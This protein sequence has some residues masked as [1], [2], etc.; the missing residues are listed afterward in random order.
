VKCF[1]SGADAI[2]TCKSCGRGLSLEYAA[3]FP[4]GLACKNRCEKDVE[5]LIALIERNIRLSAT[6]T[7]LVKGSGGATAV[8]GF[9]FLFMGV[10]FLYFGI[11]ETKITLFTLMGSGFVVYAIYMLMRANSLRKMNQSPKA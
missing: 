6:T 4:R 10:V 9:F 8:S 7:S 2:G 11:F 1:Y 3:E 5:T